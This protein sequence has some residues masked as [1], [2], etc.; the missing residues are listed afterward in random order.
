MIKGPGMPP[1]SVALKLMAK[2]RMQEEEAK[3]SSSNNKKMTE[4]DMLDEVAVYGRV[5]KAKELTG[6]E[7][8][9]SNTNSPYREKITKEDLIKEGL[10]VE[11]DGDL[12]PTQKYYDW[13]K[14]GKL[15][16]KYNIN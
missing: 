13:K 6:S 16:G 9:T 1:L 5:A 12:F 15:K 4:Q 7:E 14:T 8:N 2:K 3:L 11:K 10:F